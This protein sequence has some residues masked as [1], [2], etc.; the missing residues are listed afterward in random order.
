LDIGISSH[1][2]MCLVIATSKKSFANVYGLLDQIPYDTFPKQ[3]ILVVS[4]QEDEDSRDDIGG[5]ACRRV[6]YTGLEL[7]SFIHVYENLQ[8]YDRFNWW[9]MLPD[10]VEFGPTFFD[11]LLACY[12]THLRNNKSLWCLPFINNA[13]V[14]RPTM[15]LGICSSA[16]LFNIG[17]Y[18][19]QMKLV[20][21]YG[22]EDVANLKKQLICNEN[23][24]FGI[25]TPRPGLA[26]PLCTRIAAA[27]PVLFLVHDRADIVE[28]EIEGGKRNRVYL[29]PL[30]LY[31]YQRNFRGLDHPLVLDE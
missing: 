10:T 21:P 7:T 16:H 23:N 30:D 11:K 28:E 6:T 15:D 3:N 27:T 5:V 29:A 12:N 1:M 13:Q 2:D 20:A 17:A 25:Q 14:K 31:K 18:L 8:E 22:K 19:I 24:V 26:T 9:V 4:G